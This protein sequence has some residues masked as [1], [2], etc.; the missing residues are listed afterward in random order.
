MTDSTEGRSDLPWGGD[1]A[2]VRAN[3]VRVGDGAPVE[4][5]AEAVAFLAGPRAGHITSATLTVEPSAEKAGSHA[6]V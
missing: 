1:L 5:V 6:A 2:Y 3:E 4:D